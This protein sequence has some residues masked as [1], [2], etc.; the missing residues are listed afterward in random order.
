MDMFME[1]GEAALS[2]TRAEAVG[3]YLTRDGALLT[4]PRNWNTAPSASLFR[5]RNPAS[6]SPIPPSSPTKRCLTGYSPQQEPESA[7]FL[8]SFNCCA[9]PPLKPLD[10]A[11]MAD[12]LASFNFREEDPGGLDSRACAC[13]EELQ[14]QLRDLF[15]G[16]VTTTRAER[17]AT[18]LDLAASAELTLGVSEGENNVL[19]GLSTLDPSLGGALSTAISTDGDG[20]QTTR[21]VLVGDALANQPPDEPVLQSSIA[22]HVVEG[23]SQVDGSEWTVRESSQDTLGWTFSYICKGSMQHWRRQNKGHQKTQV[24]DYSHKELDPVS[25]G[26]PA[27]DCRGSITVSFSRKAR[28]V[29]I[30][31][32]HIPLHRTV[33]EL[34][35]LY[36]P[37]FLRHPLPTPEKQ[38][39]APRQPGSSRKKRD[40][41]KTANGENNKSRKRKRKTDDVGVAGEQG[42]IGNAVEPQGP[43]AQTGGDEG[44]SSAGQQ[45]LD[46]AG[47]TSQSSAAGLLIINVT[48]EE[49]ERRRTVAMAMLQ[50]SG[51]EPDTLS[52][53]QFNIFANQSPDLQKESLNMLVKY[54]A[55]R[56]RIVHPGSKEGSVQPPSRASSSVPV[57]QGNTQE[58]STGPVTTNELVLQTS[59]SANTKKGRRKIQTANNASGEAG[60][61]ANTTGVAKKTRR[62]GTAK[63]RNACFQCKQRKV[64]CPRETPICTEC[65]EAGLICEFPAPKPRI[66]KSN[67]IITAEDEQDENGQEEPL[68]EVQDEAPL[69]VHQ[70]LQEDDA[71]GYPD[72]EDD[73]AHSQ[74]PIGDALS[75]NLNVTD[76]ESNHNPSNYFPSTNMEVSEASSS[77]P[78]HPTGV[79][80][81]DLV[82]LILPS[83]R[84]YY[85]N[86]TAVNMPDQTLTQQRKSSTQSSAHHGSARNITTR[87][88]QDDDHH[89]SVN[90]TPSSEWSNGGSPVTQAAAVVAAVVTSMQDQNSHES[91][92]GLQDSSG[93]G[94]RSSTW[95]PTPMDDSQQP[96]TTGISQ[97]QGVSA[98]SLQR[99]GAISP[100]KD[101]PRTKPLKG[102]RGA[103]RNS[104]AAKPYHSP[105]S[106]DQQQ[107]N[108]HGPG[109]QA[110]V[111]MASSAAY[112]SYD[113]YSSTRGADAA[114]SND[115]ISYEP[116][117]YQKD[118]VSTTPYTSYGHGSHATTSAA[119]MPAQ[120]VTEMP[121]TDRP[122][123]QTYGPYTDS[124]PRN[125]SQT[126]SA[127][128][129]GPRANAQT[130]DFNN[131]SSDSSHNSRQA[132]HMRSQSAISR[133]GQNGV[134]QDRNFL[135]YPSH[136]QQQQQQQ[137]QTQP[138]AP[139]QH[140]QQANQHQTWY[141]FDNHPSA[142]YAPNSGHGS[143]YSWNMPGDS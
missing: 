89:S 4:P 132:F 114:A 64:K 99:S 96:P 82:N 29:S 115:R 47:Q 71:E 110:P 129:L 70:Q 91:V 65:R 61:D 44:S 88:T 80:I 52:P 25:S 23:L 143:N 54:G 118:A 35:T 111:G 92:Y 90:P 50:H 5:D 55:E 9:Q 141:G 94:A 137:Q 56:L 42:A 2:S 67:A 37:L 11:S 86:V 1:M 93:A 104:S 136:M 106:S 128:Y 26:R 123:S 109:L 124:A 120:T 14:L 48:P 27:F 133:P 81:S 17:V 72:I 112:N 46:Q 127:S 69:E 126:H 6:S 33:A 85:S 125:P 3:L 101:I 40:A 74:M 18:R 16:K 58:G 7:R 100:I 32:D 131:S 43:A 76:W 12:F 62:R 107:S 103:V 142:S 87:L 45:Q 49:A 68:A 13:V 22:N 121:S 39:K 34:A 10:G 134:K 36:K 105:T 108:T 122:G 21:V 57:T 113:R 28:T 138:R 53:E 59:T 8:E 116:Y 24:A 75:N 97:K 20:G 135:T 41:D 30:D 117:S 66:A 31:Y 140:T 51:V 95:R 78:S 84:P 130:Q 63:S 77:Q 119:P 19:E 73:A 60:A 79:P 83:G 38:P 15:N 98:A 102:K 139:Q